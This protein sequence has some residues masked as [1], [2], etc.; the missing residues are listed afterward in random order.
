MYICGV[1]IDIT[2]WFKG[3]LR[4]SASESLTLGAHPQGKLLHLL[5]MQLVYYVYIHVVLHLCMYCLYKQCAH[6]DVRVHVH[7]YVHLK[8]PQQKIRVYKICVDRCTSYIH[9]YIHREAGECLNSQTFKA[10]TYIQVSVS[11]VNKECT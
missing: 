9:V 4:S 6:T 8:V 1:Y 2:K 7:L 3:H 10:C 11:C 5:V